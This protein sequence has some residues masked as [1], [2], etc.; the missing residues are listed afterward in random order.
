M[1]YK[2]LSYTAFDGI[3]TFPDSFIRGLFERMQAE[4]LVDSVFHEGTVRTAD[5]FL[6]IMKY[7]Q[8]ILFVIEF[9]GKIEGCCWLNN[10]GVRTGNFHFCFFSGLRGQDAV[11]VGR[12][13]VIELL[14]MTDNGGNPIFDLLY[15]FVETENFPAMRWCRHMGFET[16]GV[17]PSVAWN[18]K[19]KQSVP[20]QYWYVERGNY[21]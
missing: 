3:P 5:E 19:K 14:N 10:F 8:N 16:V 18:A 7:N 12:A 4:N 9:K 13:V 17:I 6:R 15:G 2:L 21:G 11:D 1:D 20:A